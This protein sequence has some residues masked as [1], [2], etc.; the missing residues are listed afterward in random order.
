VYHLLDAFDALR[1]FV[2]ATAQR[3]EGAIAYLT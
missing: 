1:S 3:R 2:A